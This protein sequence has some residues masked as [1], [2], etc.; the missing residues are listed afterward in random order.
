MLNVCKSRDI[1]SG[2]PLLC[3]LGQGLPF[4]A[5]SFDGAVSI[6]CIQWL[7]N[8]DKSSHRPVQRLYKFF[9]TLYSCL[10][11]NS[12]AVFQFYPE[13]S[14]QIE[15]I[16]SQAMKAGFTGGLVVD[17]PNSTKAKKMFL[18]LFTGG[19]DNK[20]PKG[21]SEEH[22]STVAFNNNRHTRVQTITVRATKKSKAWIIAKKERRRR[23]G[24][25]VRDDSKY[26]G[27]KRNGHFWMP[28]TIDCLMNWV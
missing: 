11:R 2:D 13:N 16:T 28:F 24:K 23:Q 18:V 26:T 12:R 4:R 27:R 9:S 22:K 21:L 8:A 3:D 5:G 10:S 19:T 6:S 14:S 20:L 7:C 1:E 17:Y 25:E 15:L